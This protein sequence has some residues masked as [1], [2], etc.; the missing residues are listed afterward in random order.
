MFH[1][2][3]SVHQ[4]CDST[5]VQL[6]SSLVPPAGLSASRRLHVVVKPIRNISK[7]F[8][9]LAL[10]TRPGRYEQSVYFHP[11]VSPCEV[12]IIYHW[13]ALSR[14]LRYHRLHPEYT[15]PVHRT[16][17][18]DPPQ[19]R[20]L[21]LVRRIPLTLTHPLIP[22]S[23]QKTKILFVSWP[24]SSALMRARV[25]AWAVGWVCESLVW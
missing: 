5:V 10:N 2:I 16:S 19:P 9:G 14:C 25:R 23:S 20:I 15:H 24:V 6:P 12:C 21:L 17:G 3:S 13:L 1:T 7:R 4:Y 11:Q 22:L 18:P 8:A